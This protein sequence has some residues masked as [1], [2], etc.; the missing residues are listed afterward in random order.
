MHRGARKKLTMPCQCLND[1]VELV[2]DGDAEWH[3]GGGLSQHCSVRKIKKRKL[4]F[5]FVLYHVGD[6][7]ANIASFKIK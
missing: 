7:D 2:A 3:D 4:R 5:L 6:E 1:G